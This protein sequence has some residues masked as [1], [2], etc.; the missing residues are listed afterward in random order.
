[1]IKG[2]IVL[3]P[4]SFTDLTGNKLRPALVLANTERQVIVAFITSQ[5]LWKEDADIVLAPTIENGLKKGLVA[6]AF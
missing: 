6:P 2:N 3:V 5:I 1:M 4:F